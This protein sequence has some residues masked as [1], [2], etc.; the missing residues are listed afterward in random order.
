M[1]LL[2]LAVVVFVAMAIE[3]R[4]AARNERAQRARGGFEPPGDVYQTMRVV[5]PLSFLAMLV[6]GALAGG[7]SRATA[8]A[9]VSVFA[10]AK[11][12]KWWAIVSL[13][14]FWTFRVIVIKGVALVI[15]GPYRWLRHPNYVA[16]MGELAGVALITGAVWSGVTALAVFGL[17]LI[18]RMT[19]EE[20]A[21]DAA[22]GPSP[23][24]NERGLGIRD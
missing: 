5:Y 16:V 23:T 15:R 24:S 9:G 8:L 20:R 11:A 13:G 19:V 17:L 4:R 12:L 2:S 7:P 18:K 14:P 10:A 1:R 21:L 22:R 3:A 6:E